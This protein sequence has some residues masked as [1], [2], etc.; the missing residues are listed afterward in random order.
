[1]LENVRGLLDPA[2]HEYRA[3]ISHHLEEFGYVP[4]WRLLNASMFG[5]PQLRPRTILVAL[6]DVDKGNFRWPDTQVDCMRPAPTVGTVLRAEMA[7]NG[8]EGADAWALKANGIAPTLV[9]G[10]KKHGGPDLG[11]TRARQAWAKLCVNGN[12]LADEPPEPGFTG[13]PYL[14]VKMAALIQGFPT[15]WLIAGKKTP[16]YRQIGNAFP[17]PVAHAMGQSIRRAFARTEAQQRELIEA[18]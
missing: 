12:R 2:F 4:E 11:P 17:P 18:D 7:S 15:D 16:A 1:M 14:T 9:G 5:V 13:M 3:R 6:R 8:W 10:S